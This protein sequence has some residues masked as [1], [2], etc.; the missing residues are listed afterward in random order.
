MWVIII[1]LP[2][3]I[4]QQYSQCG[5]WSYKKDN[6]IK[7]QCYFFCNGNNHQP[8]N[9][10]CIDEEY[11][12]GTTICLYTGKC[13]ICNGPHRRDFNHCLLKSMYSKLRVSTKSIDRLNISQ[14][15]G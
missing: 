14:I 5:K 10:V 9:H 2:K 6:F 15:Y 3:E 11:T 8:S 13:I 1:L 12:D 7:K 4:S